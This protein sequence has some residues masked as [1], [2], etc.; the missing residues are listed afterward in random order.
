LRAIGKRKD[1]H[2]HGDPKDDR[3]PARADPDRRR[4]HPHAG[5]VRAA[6]PPQRHPPGPV[7]HAGHSAA[8][9][10]PARP[11]IRC[12]HRS[13]G[14]A[15]QQQ[16][17]GELCRALSAGAGAGSSL[18]NEFSASE[19]SHGE[20]QLLCLARALLV[21]SKI[22]IFDEAMGRYVVGLVVS[23]SVMCLANRWD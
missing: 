16:P 4:G 14:T 17:L 5:R 12:L 23:L 13:G 15:G 21:P 3:P 9:P 11:S 6:C 10:G 2:N 7:F 18:D 20:H 8:Q 1:V 19:L 22:I